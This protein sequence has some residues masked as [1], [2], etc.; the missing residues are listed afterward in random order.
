MAN[1]SDNLVLEHLRH[2]RSKVDMIGDDMQTLTLR[3]GSI[4]RI[5]AG[6]QV[7]EATQNIELDRLKLR[8]DRI[9]RRLE[10]SETGER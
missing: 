7:V 5:L 6:H 10:L 2:I 3:V 8:V 9:E 1:T 4:E